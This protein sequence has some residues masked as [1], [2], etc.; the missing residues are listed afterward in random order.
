[1]VKGTFVLG[2]GTQ[3]AGTSWLQSYLAAHPNV[4]FGPLKEYHTFNALHLRVYAHILERRDATPFHKPRKFFSHLHRNGKMPANERLRSRLRRGDNYFGFFASILADPGVDVT[5]DITSDYAGLNRNILQAIRDTFSREGV[6][7]KALFL[8]RDPVERCISAVRMYMGRPYE[9]HRLPIHP[10]M[11]IE[12][13]LRR[14]YATSHFEGLTRYD[15]T[16]GEIHVVF[17]DEDVFVGFYETLFCRDEVAQIDRFLGLK[18][19][20][21]N[22]DKRV[23]ASGFKEQTVTGDLRAS[24]AEHYRPVYED[25]FRRFGEDRIRAIWPSA[26]LLN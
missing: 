23:N 17:P 9:S 26:A 16:L 21:P 12:D 1:M 5:G 10:G 2:L 25:V 22:L 4:D 20:K 19:G 15:R 18:P 3:K 11:S 6:N 8:M 24:M 7:V 13:S 14:L